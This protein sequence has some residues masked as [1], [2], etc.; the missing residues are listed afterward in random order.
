MGEVYVGRKFTTKFVEGGKPD[1]QLIAEILASGKRL[2]DLGLTPENAGNLSVRTEDGLLITVGGINKGELTED[3]VV[4][5]V[6]FDFKDAKVVGTKEPSSEV[7]MHYLIYQSYP[8]AN[9]VVHVHDELAL[10]N[11]VKLKV[12]LGISTTE[13]K[14]S[15][16]TQD[17]AFEVI[18]ALSH[19]QYA[20]IKGHGIV[21]MGASLA[22]TTDLVLK[23]HEKLRK[24]SDK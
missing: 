6:D 21:C 2:N 17:Q 3:D 10:D 11:A 1:E 22:E 7:P 24:M 20:I 19:A 5:V 18:E 8:L 12:A 4:E 16:G 13:V 9:A 14:A 23:I 15:Y